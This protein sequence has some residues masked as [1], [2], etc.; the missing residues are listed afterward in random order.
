MN[1]NLVVFCY[2]ILLKFYAKSIDNNTTSC[3]I[4]KNSSGVSDIS[5]VLSNEYK[6]Y[7]CF[8]L[9]TTNKKPMYFLDTGTATPS[10]N[11]FTRMIKQIEYIDL[12]ET[13]GEGNEPTTIDDLYKTDKGRH[14]LSKD[15]IPYSDNGDSVY[16]ESLVKVREG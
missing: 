12:T 16:C 13:F 4:V 11:K 1:K 15:Y 6:L 5:G 8:Y 7:T 3:T 2:A 9:K 10:N 14:I